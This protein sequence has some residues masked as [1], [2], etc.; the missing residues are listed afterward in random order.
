MPAFRLQ[1]EIYF[2]EA[3]SIEVL[4][5]HVLVWDF[6][7][8]VATICRG[9]DSNRPMSSTRISPPFQFDASWMYNLILVQWAHNSTADWHVLYAESWRIWSVVFADL[10]IIVQVLLL[11]NGS[12]TLAIE[13]VDSS[14]PLA[15]SGTNVTKHH[16]PQ[17]KSMD[18]REWFAVHLESE[19]YFVG[20]HF[21]PRDRYGVVEDLSFLEVSICTK[22]LKMSC[23]KSRFETSAVLDDTF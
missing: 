4:L 18:F 11:L 15:R 16:S 17:R 6:V 14:E 1:W 7:P 22:E 12:R 13:H 23:C 20:L 2:P 3:P 8:D 5:A 19:K 10:G 9:L 21:S